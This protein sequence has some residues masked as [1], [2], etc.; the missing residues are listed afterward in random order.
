ME[1]VMEE[2]GDL[3]GLNKIGDM[4]LSETIGNPRENY[5][6][7]EKIVNSKNKLWHIIVNYGVI[8]KVIHKVS[9]QCRTLKKIVLELVEVKED[10][11]LMLKE[12]ALLRTLVFWI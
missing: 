9:K 12:L 2:I 4:L 10:E 5:D 1:N 11:T 8:K 3:G 6:F 7:Y